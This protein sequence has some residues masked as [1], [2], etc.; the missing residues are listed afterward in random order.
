MKNLQYDYTN[1]LETTIG[2]QGLNLEK[3]KELES[4][5]VAANKKF[6]TTPDASEFA[7]HRLLEASKELL[8]IKYTAN[9]L[10]KSFE[11][12]IVIGVGGSDL[13]AR[14][15]IG[16][17]KSYYHNELPEKKRGGMRVYFC[18]DTTDPKPLE[19]LLENIDLQKTAINVISKSGN[20]L[21]T[22]SVFF[23]IRQKLI[24][25]VGVNQHKNHIIVTTDPSSGYLQKIAQKEGY[26]VLAHDTVGG[27]FSVLSTTGLLACACAGIDID[28]LIAGAQEMRVL[29]KKNAVEKNSSFLFAAIN[30]LGYKNGKNISVLMP[31][32]YKLKE[33][34]GWFK[35]LWGES[36]GK[37]NLGQ[38]PVNSLGPTDQHSQ[39]QLYQQGPFD[40]IITFIKSEAENE[41]KTPEVKTDGIEY[42]GENK[43]KDLLDAE[44]EAT[45][46]AL[47]Q[48]GKMNGTI[49]VPEVNEFYIGQLIY[50][51]EL[52]TYYSGELYEINAF[53][54][55]GV[56]L[57]KNYIHTL[58]GKPNSKEL[59]DKLKE[60]S[61]IKKSLV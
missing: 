5:L 10:S 55:P 21:E 25:K 47:A 38:T 3:I 1:I 50:F 44:L 19:E 14:A 39:L 45:A 2:S 60:K 37:N 9:F 32:D 53:D 27:R 40:K 22:M 54:Q 17:L 11:N 41:L 7:F 33:F 8:A 23:A 4:K 26:R 34:G 35:Q 57:G 61:K 51:F 52:A 43:F 24:K 31:Y 18:G 30:Y 16:A 36:L 15:V 20:T 58:I 49:I 28:N 6:T 12:L 13:G 29:T 42:F 59:L 48:E 56:E 46:T